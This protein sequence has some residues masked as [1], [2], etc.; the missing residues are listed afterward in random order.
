MTTARTTCWACGEVTVPV[1]GITLVLDSPTEPYYTFNCPACKGLVRKAAS[2]HAVSLLMEAGVLPTRMRLMSERFD[3]PP[4][5]A[6]DVVRLRALLCGEEWF[7]EL[8]R[9][10]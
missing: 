2:E 3:H 6:E 10:T 4:L 8:E 1:T 9:L 7:A 5:S